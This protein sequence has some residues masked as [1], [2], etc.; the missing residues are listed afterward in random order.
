MCK[1]N[2][3]IALLLVSFLV[4]LFGSTNLVAAPTKVVAQHFGFSPAHVIA[5][6]REQIARHG[7]KK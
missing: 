4:V 2:P 7:P 1:R 3:I 6:A 5:A